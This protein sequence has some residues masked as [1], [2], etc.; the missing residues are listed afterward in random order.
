[1]P[2]VDDFKKAVFV[3]DSLTVGLKTAISSITSFATVGHTVWQ[4]KDK[5]HQSIVDAKPSIIIMSYGT[6]DAGYQNPD[7]FKKEFVG[8]INELK[9]ALPGVQIFVNKIFPGDESKASGTGLTCIKNIPS[10]NEVIPQIIQEAGATLLDCTTIPNL[11][12]YYSNDGIHF[13]SNF[14]PYYRKHLFLSL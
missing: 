2:S 13:N 6:N 9:Q 10:L 8:W 5:H 1:M 14:N 3:G 11:K 4:G 7:K 12:T